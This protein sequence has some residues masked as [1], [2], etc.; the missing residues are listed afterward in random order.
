[1]PVAFRLPLECVI[2]GL[3]WF[4]AHNPEKH[5]TCT[6]KAQ[7]HWQAVRYPAEPEQ[8]ALG[9]RN[10]ALKRIPCHFTL[11][12]QCNSQSFHHQ[13][14]HIQAHFEWDDFVRFRELCN[15]NIT[16]ARHSMQ[17]HEC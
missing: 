17:E 7:A 8:E 10:A 14:R 1:M 13:A 11:F 9:R 15:I 16:E 2:L 12:F 6:N 4:A 5:P 3:T